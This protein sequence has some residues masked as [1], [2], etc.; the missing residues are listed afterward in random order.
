M[1][2]LSGVRSSWD[3]LARNSDLCG[4]R[5]RAADR[6]AQLVAHAVQVRGQRPELVAVR[7]LDLLRE[8]AG[9]ISSKRA[10]ICLTGPISD[11]EIA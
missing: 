1:I 9:A 8:I 7:H 11:H 6:A 3:M 4:S 5:S 10:S 2:A